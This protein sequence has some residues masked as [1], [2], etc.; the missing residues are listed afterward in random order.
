VTRREYVRMEV[1][2]SICDGCENVDQC[3]LSMVNTHSDKTGITITRGEIVEALTELVKSGLAKAEHL[4]PWPGES[5]EVE[6]MPT[7]DEIEEF[8]KTYFF[9]TERGMEVHLSNG[10]RWPRDD[11]GNLRPGWHLDDA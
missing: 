11:E 7:M 9:I 2:N 8:F 1:L 6:G 10:P 5:V 3:I 4:S